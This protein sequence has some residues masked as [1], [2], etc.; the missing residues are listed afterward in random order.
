LEVADEVGVELSAES[1]PI[2]D[3]PL[4]EP[5]SWFIPAIP[6]LAVEAHPAKA[7]EAATRP[8]VTKIDFLNLVFI[9]FLTYSKIL[10]ITKFSAQ[11]YRMRLEFMFG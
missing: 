11:R 8:A 6:L 9:F 5:M 1:E 7:K 3:I 4:I 2:P 10:G